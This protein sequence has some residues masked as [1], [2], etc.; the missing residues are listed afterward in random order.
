MGLD[1]VVQVYW[2]KHIAFQK[3]SVHLV[4]FIIDSMKNYILLSLCNKIVISMLTSTEILIKY[5]NT[6]IYKCATA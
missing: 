6:Q 2:E 1:L 4:G 5:K 3:N